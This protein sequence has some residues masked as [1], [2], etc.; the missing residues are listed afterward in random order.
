M[1]RRI[2]KQRLLECWFEDCVAYNVLALAVLLSGDGL[3]K[4]CWRYGSQHFFDKFQWKSAEKKSKKEVLLYSYCLRV[5][6]SRL[7]LWYYKGEVLMIKTNTFVFALFSFVSK[8]KY[9]TWYSYTYST[10]PWSSLN[11][12]NKYKP[13]AQH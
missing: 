3:V 6:S 5:L 1:Y 2:T 8:N 13:G 9:T 7:W 10:H 12:L 4:I 11:N